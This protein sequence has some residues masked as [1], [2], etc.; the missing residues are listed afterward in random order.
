MAKIIKDYGMV[1]CIDAVPVSSE[2]E[3]EWSTWRRD[4]IGRVGEL[5]LYESEK[6]FPGKKF[7]CFFGSKAPWELKTSYGG[8]IDAYGGMIEGSKQIIFQT[9]NTRY[10]FRKLEE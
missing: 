8:L 3:V 5:N 9:K 2:V 1:E 6:K 10:V 7:L 4:Y